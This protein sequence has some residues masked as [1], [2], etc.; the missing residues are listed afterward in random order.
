[1]LFNRKNLAAITA[2]GAKLK[3]DLYEIED[4]G[5]LA[6]VKIDFTNEDSGGE[7]FRIS[8][9]FGDGNSMPPGKT[10]SPTLAWIHSMRGVT[11]TDTQNKKIHRVAYDT[12]GQCLCDMGMRSTFVSEGDTI[13]LTASFAPL[14]DGQNTATVTIPN[15]GTFKNVPINR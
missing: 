1:M 4:D 6:T 14:P 12:S 11:L 15:F 10:T 9:F 13:Q 5:A 7:K 8:G 2:E 3:I